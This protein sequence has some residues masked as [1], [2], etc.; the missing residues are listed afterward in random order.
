M[1]VTVTE[2]CNRTR[3]HLPIGD[4]RTPGPE[5]NMYA[6]TATVSEENKDGW[7]STRQVP[8]F[9]LDEA[10][11]GIVSADHAERIARDVINP[12]GLYE[13]HAGAVRVD[14]P[15]TDAVATWANGFG[16]W[17]VRVPRHAAS[18]LLAARRALRDELQ[19]RE[20]NLRREVWLHPE[21]VED[22]DTEDTIV[23]RENTTDPAD[24]HTEPAAALTI[25]AQVTE[26][27]P[28]QARTHMRS[29]QPNPR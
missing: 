7:I 5:L 25:F 12:F 28:P 21:R 26:E 2:W 17:H 24:E 18:P 15:L 11:Q 8:T 4:T 19:L 29:G 16:V 20:V 13:V 23:Y 6:I 1:R 27:A 14:P 9:Y 10:V 3:R 22:L